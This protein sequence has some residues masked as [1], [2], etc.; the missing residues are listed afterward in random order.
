[1]MVIEAVAADIGADLEAADVA[2]I[3]STHAISAV[4]KLNPK[5]ICYCVGDATT[6]RAKAAGLTPIKGGDTA[7][8]VAQRVIADR[9]EGRII[10][11][12]GRHVAFDMVGHLRAAGLSAQEVVVYDQVA[13]ALS[14]EAVALLRGDAKVVLPLFSPRS[15]TLFF[16]ACPEAA[17]LRIIAMS[18][19]VADTVPDRYRDGMHV[20][21]NPDAEA[22]A[23]A[24]LSVASGGNRLEPGKP[25]Q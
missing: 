21:P 7:Q 6:Q 12:R 5:P 11:P 25:A 10:Y 18:E 17:Q 22:M 8:A 4:T 24:V 14:P 13:A 15:S 20:V 3:T 2:V 9:P 23:R 1:M 16:E 19:T